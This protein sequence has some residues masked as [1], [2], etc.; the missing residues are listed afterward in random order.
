MQCFKCKNNIE[1][2]AKVVRALG[3]PWHIT[4]LACET[5]R[6]ALSVSTYVGHQKTNTVYC[7]LHFPR[8]HVHDNTKTNNE[9]HANN[10]LHSKKD[11]L[12]SST[13][14]NQKKEHIYVLE[15]EHECYYIGKTYNVDRRFAQHVQGQDCK[16]TSIHP[17]KRVICQ[18]PVTSDLDEIQTTIHY[19]QIHGIDKVRGG[20]FVSEQLPEH[21]IKTIADMLHTTKN[22]CFKCGSNA[23]YVKDCPQIE[24][25][26]IFVYDCS[27]SSSSEDD[28]D[29]HDNCFRCGRPGHWQTSCQYRIHVDGHRL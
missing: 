28:D 18:K 21:Q 16:W 8:P 2:S 23:H 14:A 29:D 25:S 22:T 15:L 11:E 5:C 20:S 4:C 12:K 19:M 27:E 7:R 10:Q 24:D 9:T 1:D 13:Q 17:P 6:V 26:R 3:K